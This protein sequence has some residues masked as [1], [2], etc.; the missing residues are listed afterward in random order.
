MNTILQSALRNP[1]SAMTSA[2]LFDAAGTLFRV[3]GSVGE[4]YAM[5]AAHHGV[6]VDPAGIEQRFRAA[7]RD[8]PPLAFPDA[9]EPELPQREYAW[10]KHLAGT[11][12][13]AC[14]FADFDVFFRDL[15]E[16]FAGAEAWELFPDVCPSLTALKG[17]GLR[18]AVVSNFDGRLVRVCEG[19]SIADL[20]DTLVMSGRAGYVKP[21][22]RIF[23]I[24]LE[25]LGV[26]ATDAVH[27]GD[28]QSED[29]EAA[30]AAGL[31]ALLLRRDVSTDLAPGEIHDL[32]EL[33]DRV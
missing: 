10:W 11:V 7:F 28:S 18:L 19:L 17:R 24:A 14:R 1:K 16:Y 15:F 5:V 6:R 26:T 8:M 3:R 21:D 20:F 27:V 30:R 33:V 29:I 31:R 23:A 2:V 9:P 25:R 13:A 22:P 32:R 12:F 4:A